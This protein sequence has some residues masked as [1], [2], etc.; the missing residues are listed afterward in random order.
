MHIAPEGLLELRGGHDLTGVG[1][2]QLKGGKLHG[3]QMEQRFSPEQ[4]AVGFKPEAGEEK[5][6]LFAAAVGALVF[7]AGR[8]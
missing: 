8:G 3:R 5:G 4:G 7:E 1:E 2:Q 6:W